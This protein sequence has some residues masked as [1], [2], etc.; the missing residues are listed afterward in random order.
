MYQYEQS[1]KIILIEIVPTFLHFEI[2]ISSGVDVTAG[3]V[4]K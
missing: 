4:P 3:A 2:S 1:S